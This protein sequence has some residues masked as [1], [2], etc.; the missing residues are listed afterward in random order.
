MGGQSG[1]SPTLLPMKKNVLESMSRAAGGKKNLAA[2]SFTCC[3]GQF[4]VYCLIGPA[5][6]IYH[7]SFSQTNHR[8]ARELLA[9]LNRGA[10]LVDLPQ[11]KFPHDAMLAAY[12]AGER[13]PFP[14]GA[15]S[16]FFAAGTAFQQRV[17]RHIRAIPYGCTMTYRELALRASSP[18]GA[19]PAAGA[20]GANPLALIVPCHRVVASDGPGGF[21]GGVAVK[22]NLLALE[23][24]AAGGQRCLQ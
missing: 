9:R 13:I 10:P 8:R 3:Y 6:T 18:Q 15:G 4:T 22:K 17:W 12:F 1:F 19:R 2:A 14:V 21:A 16:P 23:Q 11:K 7:L 24:G 5:D 20:C